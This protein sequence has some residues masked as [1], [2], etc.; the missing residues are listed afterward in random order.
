MPLVAMIALIHL[1]TAMAKARVRRTKD[2]KPKSRCLDCNF[3]HIQYA[4]N[5]RRATSCTFN[6]GVRPVA[7]DVLYCTD[8]R[9]R[10][11][12]VECRPLGFVRLDCVERELVKS[13]IHSECFAGGEDEG[14][15]LIGR[16]QVQVLPWR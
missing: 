16:P 6:G 5:G 13:E 14:Y 15:F 9:V 1:I 10:D 4:A 2:N 3:A 12:V 11:P 7:L 8:F